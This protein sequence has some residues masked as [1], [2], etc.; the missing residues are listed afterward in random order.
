MKF[1]S[2]V[3]DIVVLEEDKIYQVVQCIAMEGRGYLVIRRIRMNLASVLQPDDSKTEFV[4]ELLDY[5]HNY[6]FQTV[7]DQDVI[8]KINAIMQKEDK[9]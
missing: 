9:E 2:K 3:G 4:E 1:I 5:N 7:T 6:Y 8:S